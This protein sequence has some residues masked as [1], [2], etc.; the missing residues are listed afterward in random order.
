MIPES[1]T[2]HVDTGWIIRQLRG[3]KEY[4]AK[5]DELKLIIAP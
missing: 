4:T 3:R 5:L 2:Y 1:L